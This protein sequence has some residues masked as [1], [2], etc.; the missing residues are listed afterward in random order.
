LLGGRRFGQRLVNICDEVFEASVA[1]AQ[2]SGK[3]PAISSNDE[4]MRNARDC[5]VAGNPAGSIIDHIDLPRSGSPYDGARGVLIL[6]TH[7]EYRELIFAENALGSLQDRQFPATGCAPR[8][9]ESQDHDFSSLAAEKSAFA[10]D[11]IVCFKVWSDRSDCRA[12]RTCSHVG[13]EREIQQ[14]CRDCRQSSHKSLGLI[15]P[16]SVFRNLPERSRAAGI[17]LFL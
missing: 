17:T 6:K 7:R 2:M 8:S 16:F 13:C 4:K 5:V 10:S 14:R 1:V 9:P 15:D 11:Q 12:D 3:D